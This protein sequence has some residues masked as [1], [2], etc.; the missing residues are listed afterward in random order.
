[1]RRV[2]VTGIGLVT[3]LGEGHAATWDRLLAGDTAIGPLRGF[4][5][6][7][8]RTRLGAELTGFDPGRY[9]SRRTLRSTTREDQLA[10]AGVALAVRDSGYDPDTVD[11]ERLA[12]FLGGNKEIS[13]PQH[14]IDGVLTVRDEDG[15]ADVRALGERMTSSFYPLF[16]VEGLQA[17]ALF[18]VSQA[19]RAMGAN[20][21]FHGSA[22]AGA[23]AIARAYRSVRRG[24]SEVAIAGG[25]DSGVSFWSMSKLDGMGVLSGRN[26]LGAAAFRPYHRERSGCLLGE[27]AAMLVL[28]ER[29][30]ALRRGATP[31]AEIEGAGAAFDAGELVAP[32]RDGKGLTAAVS[33]ALREAGAADGPDY[34]ASHGSATAS[35]D[36]SEARGLRAAL[37]PR[38]R[39]VMGSTVKP[40]I[41]HLVAAAGA[42]NVAVAALA[43][44][45]GAVPPTLN[46][47]DPDPQCDFDWVPGEARQAPVRRAV[48]LARGLAGQ[49]VALALA[50]P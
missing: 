48:A 20:A 13:N 46:L 18:Y 4:D 27:G 33:A 14:L 49:N 26:E 15:T 9:A 1:M 25:F 41:G 17:A 21:Y 23:T 30:A 35:G 42:A 5:A 50:T 47:D 16:Y 28:E 10:L 34:V 6:R 7:S 31:Y 45:H 40:A 2:V 38:A 11:V 8:L 19:Q 39:P 29:S 22:E 44:R 36:A 32:E 43:I 3:P 37:G 12:V 24:E